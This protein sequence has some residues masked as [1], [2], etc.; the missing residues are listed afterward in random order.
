MNTIQRLLVVGAACGLWLVP[1][2]FV[3]AQQPAA[4][5]GGAPSRG[6]EQ[7]LLLKNGQVLQGR[8]VPRG[9]RYMVFSPG[10]ELQIKVAEVEKVC[11]TMDE[12]YAHR[13]LSMQQDS[14][15]A[16]LELAQWCLRAGVLEGARAELLDAMALDHKHPLVPLVQRRLELATAPPDRTREDRPAAP[17]P[18][19][20]GPSTEELERMVH[21]MS[22]KT[23][24]TFTR[25][26]Q[27]ILLNSCA[28]AS[29]HGQPAAKGFQ[30][31]RMSTSNG[32]S[33]RLTQRNLYA[34]L[35]LV[36][37]D[38][39]AASPLVT[40]PTK[41]H[42]TAKAPV[43]TSQQLPQYRQLVDWCYRASE[44]SSPV[45]P[46]A[47]NEPAE[48]SGRGTSRTKA[49]P[50]PR[51]PQKASAPAA[52]GRIRLTRPDDGAIEDRDEEEDEDPAS[53]E[54]RRARVRRGGILK[55]APVDP[56]DPEAFNRRYAP[57]LRSGS[58]QLPKDVKDLID[59]SENFEIPQFPPRAVQ[60]IPA[61]IP[62]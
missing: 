51:T 15:Q 45:A 41:A 47:Y 23:V 6:Q 36:D 31:S 17:R 8:V 38:D 62:E 18:L 28:T 9:D 48:E 1:G 24:E 61:E 33:S 55:T 39:P 50:S 25:N 19:A 59:P 29:C 34:V 56:V 26:V 16:H 14:A 22:P 2:L 21:G 42:G 58:R 20:P 10:T 43:F 54:A 11:L 27:P 3:S 40:V 32:A 37:H 12:V 49:A 35:Q 57:P 30:L 5:N 52:S 13:R 53:I 60:R 46:V 44:M 7:V 4:P